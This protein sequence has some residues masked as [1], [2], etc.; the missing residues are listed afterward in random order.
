MGTPKP[1][2]RHAFVDA[3]KRSTLPALARW[4]LVVMAG[5]GLRCWPGRDRLAEQ[6]GMSVGAVRNQLRVVR[7]AGWVRIEKRSAK[8]GRFAGNLYTLTIPAAF[9]H[10][11]E[12]PTVDDADHGQDMPT[13]EDG[14]RGQLESPP[15]ASGDRDRGQLVTTNPYQGTHSVEPD[16]SECAQESIQ[17]IIQGGLGKGGVVSVDAKRKVCIKL[18]IGNA[19]PLVAL[20]DEWPGSRNARDPDAK[21]IS[22][23]PKLYRAAS[24]EVRSAC[25]PQNEPE[26]MLPIAV[27]SAREDRPSPHGADWK[28]R[29]SKYGPARRRA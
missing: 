19:D 26:A 11:Q 20:Y 17:K 14:D 9:R 15:W 25:Q 16:A 8:G 2:A 5:H 10:G 4:L 6:T 29:D 1:S 12:M 3:V 23:A 22:T 7:S 24:P 13:V 21:F 18:A 28:V 27:L